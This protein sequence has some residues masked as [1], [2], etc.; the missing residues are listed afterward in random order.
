MVILDCYGYPDYRLATPEEITSV[1]KDHLLKSLEK[2]I[3]HLIESKKKVEQETEYFTEYD[4]DEIIGYIEIFISLFQGFVFEFKRILKAFPNNIE[5]IH[6]KLIKDIHERCVYEEK[7]KNKP[8]K[9]RYITGRDFE[10][11]ESI[12]DVLSE[13]Y[14]TSGNALIRNYDLADMATRL[15]T[16]IEENE[17]K[18]KS[19]KQEL[20]SS[21]KS[22]SYE[23]PNIPEGTEWKDVFF[24]FIDYEELE[25][26]TT[27]KAYGIKG[28]E[29]LG[30]KDG[31]CRRP[32][33]LW[34]TLIILA[35]NNGKISRDT[36][37]F[38]PTKRDYSDLRRQLKNLFG[39]N[40]DPFFPWSSHKCYEVKFIIKIRDDVI[41]SL[42]SR[43]YVDPTNDISESLKNDLE[44]QMKQSGDKIKYAQLKEIKGD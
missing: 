22:I 11:K 4:I 36:K 10:G 43:Y 15:K 8:F 16:F 13:I 37:G 1:L 30:F 32:N 14:E 34:K 24:H 18:K 2:D 41:H 6:I 33:R 27:K 38:H 19:F 5:K 12:H 31:R 42:K 28:Y 39:I 9:Q 40:D 21:T 7:D 17:S 44:K 20:D 35:I 25:I 23:L 26:Q 29:T 3:E